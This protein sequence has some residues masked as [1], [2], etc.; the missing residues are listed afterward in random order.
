MIAKKVERKA[1]D[2]FARLANYILNAKEGG[3]ER[4]GTVRVQNCNSDIPAEATKEIIATQELNVLATSDRS[5]HLV[6]SFEPGE[7]PTDEQLRDIE[8]RLCEAIGLSAHQ[9]ISAVHIDKAHYHLHI[10]IN[11]IRPYEPFN[12]KEPYKDKRSLMR[13]C[14]ALEERHGLKRTN[15]GLPDERAF[16]RWI[17]TNLAEPLDLKLASIADWQGLHVL[18]AEYGL[19]LRLRGAGLIIK[20][21]DGALSVKASSVRRDLSLQTLTTRFGTFTPY[22]GAPLMPARTAY[23]RR[24]LQRIHTASLYAEYQK[25][26]ELAVAARRELR[27][28]ASKQRSF[29]SDR[30][31]A[32]RRIVNQRALTGYGKSLEHQRLDAERASS[33]QQIENGKAMGE[34]QIAQKYASSWAEFLRRAAA[35]GDANA[36]QALRQL[37]ARRQ[38]ASAA[39]LTA[40]DVAQAKEIVFRSLQST[41]KRNGEIVYRLKDGGVIVDAT[42]A[43]KIEAES[44]QAA[45]LMLALFAERW[46]NR[47]FE[48]TATE[49]F[50]RETVAIAASLG[51]PVE[52]GDRELEAERERLIVERHAIPSSSSPIDAYVAERNK[53]ALRIPSI[54]PH[55]AWVPADAGPGQYQG[56]RQ[57][58]DGTLAMLIEKGGTILVKS[59]TLGEAAK[60]RFWQIG[61]TVAI[62][63]FGRFVRRGRS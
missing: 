15:H 41:T 19:E 18:F 29:M 22:Q 17:K 28:G 8:D 10:A 59:M 1:P 4:V 42:T 46:P 6:V 43:L 45:F 30:F 16:L 50:K 51:L 33:M 9:R 7:V 26:R 5:Y 49:N 57:L 20:E 34:A 13:A 63:Q 14:A 32:L 44:S 53:L 61:K 60:A 36:A 38:Q 37:D 55:R 25:E 56:R 3:E 31:Q 35:R 11:K 2:N 39:L 52:F 27:E 23:R 62:D 48:L 58:R 21:R 47:T 40:K 54:P 24:P 12:L